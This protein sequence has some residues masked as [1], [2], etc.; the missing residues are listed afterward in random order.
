MATAASLSIRRLPFYYYTSFLSP[1][2]TSEEDI[3][4]GGEMAQDGVRGAGG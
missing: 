3:K 2:G 1:G 4:R